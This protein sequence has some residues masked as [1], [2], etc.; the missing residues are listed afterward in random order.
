M[1]PLLTVIL[2]TVLNGNL[3]EGIRELD[4][5]K[6]TFVVDLSNEVIQE[7]VEL[8]C[9]V[10]TG[11][12]VYWTTPNSQRQKTGKITVKEYVDVGNYTCHLPTGDIVDYKVILLNNP[13][14]RHLHCE[15]KN[16][17]GHFNCAWTPRKKPEQYVIQA[18]R[19]LNTIPCDAPVISD[20]RVV[21]TCHDP[22]TCVHGEEEKRILFHLHVITEKSYD[23]HEQSFALRDITKPDP[24][25]HLL[26][27]GRLL[28]WKYP[29]TWCNIHSFFPLIFNVKIETSKKSEGLNS[30]KHHKDI[31][32]TK[33]H[34][35]KK[36]KLQFC[37]QARDMFYNSSWSDWICSK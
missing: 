2:F 32:G 15:A 19:G 33:F 27:S 31:E 34:L 23:L 28:E 12:D 35:S 9:N 22:E 16:Y 4:F 8:E 1:L 7:D 18:Y 6:N 11:Q 5:L 26:N 37:V 30:W 3:A 14:S 24:P 36:G 20:S 21:V 17:S 13:E 10:S 29:K 25:Q